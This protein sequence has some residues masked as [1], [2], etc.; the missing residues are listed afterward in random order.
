[1]HMGGR[2]G[3]VFISGMGG[4]VQF[5]VVALYRAPTHSAPMS[6]LLTLRAARA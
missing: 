2:G 5:F 4:F 3:T 1:M 6:D